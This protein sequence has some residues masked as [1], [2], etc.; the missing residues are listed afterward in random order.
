MT[1]TSKFNVQSIEDV[2]SS[3]A[4]ISIT[5]STHQTRRFNG[6][7]I[8]YIKVPVSVPVESERTFSFT[9]T[10]SEDGCPSYTRT[11]KRTIKHYDLQ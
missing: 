11:I 1:I 3:S 5:G 6:E 8:I 9:V 10:V 7:D 4:K 2:P